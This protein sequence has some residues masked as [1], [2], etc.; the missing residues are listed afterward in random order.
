MSASEYLQREDAKG[1]LKVLEMLR[2]W[3]PI[4]V[5]EMDADW[6][7]DEYDGYAPEI[8]RLLDAG[9]DTDRVAQELGAIAHQRM[10][11]TTGKARDIGIAKELVE[12]WR[13]WKAR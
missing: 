2:K 10:C 6:P 13:T 9:G 12:F 1:Y 4:G 11:I 7:E 8:I 5:F 3:D